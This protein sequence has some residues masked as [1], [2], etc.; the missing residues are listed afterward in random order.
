MACI[1][2]SSKK[3]PLLKSSRV[4]GFRNASRLRGDG[5]STNLEEG[6]EHFICH[7]NCIQTYC[8]NEHIRRAQKKRKSSELSGNSPKRLR[9]SVRGCGA[10]FSF[11]HHCFL[12]GEECNLSIS[13][14]NPNRWRPAFLC[15]TGSQSW[16]KTSKQEILKRCRER[17]DEWGRE[18]KCRISSLLS[19][20]CAEGGRYHK[21]CFSKF[22]CNKPRKPTISRVDSALNQLLTCIT[23]DKMRVWNSIEVYDRYIELGGSNLSRKSLMNVIYEN[24]SPEL[25]IFSSPGIASLLVFRSNNKAFKD[26][27]IMQDVEGDCNYHAISQLAETIK[28]ECPQSD[29]FNYKARLSKEQVTSECSPTLLRL[30][31]SISEK[32]NFT[33][34][35]FMIGHIITSA[36]SGQATSLQIALSVLLSRHRKMID[37]L[38]NYGV[39]SSYDELRR[40]RISAATAMASVP[41]FDSDAGLV[42]VVADNFDTQISSQ[43]CKKSTHGLAMIVTQ[44]NQKEPN[45]TSIT[46]V[47][48]ITRLRAHELKAENLKLGEVAIHHYSGDKKPLLPEHYCLKAVPSLAFLAKLTLSLNTATMDDFAFLK[49]IVSEELCP[50]YGGFNTQKA[51]E[52]HEQP[53]S[54]TAVMYTPF[55]DM[56]P[57]EPDTMKTA[58]VEAQRLTS[59]TGQKWTIFTTDQQLYQVAV[60]ITWAERELFKN[61]I[62][63]L[64]GMHMLMSFVGCIGHLMEGSGLA[65]IMETTFGGVEKLLSGKKYPQ[66]VRALRLVVEELLR[67]FLIRTDMLT[68]K[69]LN[70]TLA[71]LSSCSKTTKLWVDCLIRPVFIIMTFIRAERA[72]DWPLHLYAVEKMLPYFFTA[73]HFNYARYGVYYLRSMQHLPSDLEK[74][75]MNGEHAMHHQAGLWNGIWSDLFIETTYMRYGHSPSGIIGSTLN[76]STLAI[77]AFSHS[78]LTQIMHDLQDLKE[79]RETRAAIIFHK[80]EQTSRL[81]EDAEDRRKIREALSTCIDV[82]D[83]NKHPESGLINIYSGYIVTDPLVNVHNA[84]DIGEAEH[85]HFEKHLTTHFHKKL[86]KKIK[87]MSLTKVSKHCGGGRHTD[88]EFLYARVLG[89]I[90]SPG[91]DVT[92]ETLLSHELAPYPLALFD[93][94]GDMCVTQKSVLKNKLQ[95]VSGK[96]NQKPPSV[97]ILDACALLWRVP[98]PASP[99]KVSDFLNEAVIKILRYAEAASI[100]HIVFDRYNK[101]STKS[102]CRSTR[103]K[104]VNRVYCFTEDMP[105]PKQTLVLNVTANKE[106]IIRMI[107]DRISNMPSVPDKQIIIT[108]PDPQ[109]IQIGG[110]PQETAVFH[111]E[112]DV[113]MAYHMIHEA[114]AGQQ[115]IKVVSEDTDVLIILAHH[116]YAETNGL[117]PNISLCMESCSES[118]SLININ[119]VIRVHRDIMPNILAA[120]ALTGCDTV[121]SFAGV[122]KA[123]AF[124]RLKTFNGLLKL[125]DLSATKEEITES[126]LQFTSMLYNHEKVNDLNMLRAEIFRRKIAGKRHVAPKLCNLPPTMDSFEAHCQRAHYQVALWKAAGLASPP[127]ICPLEC[128][129][130]VKG[131]VLHPQYSLQGQMPP[132]PEEIMNLIKCACKTGCSTALCTCTKHLLS[133]TMFC[134]CSKS[135]RCMNPQTVSVRIDEADTDG[136]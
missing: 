15:K 52:R 126:C 4:V 63:R 74:K 107:V 7:R 109:L 135:S 72:G 128:G 12:C 96:G 127:K 67:P 104:G 114:T 64:G 13:T 77:W 97:I 68:M 8:S 58:L 61:I 38:H 124:K 39:A 25:L 88:T 36:I 20:L 27:R 66:N 120:H 101:M 17:G 82:F 106:Q 76:E 37:E 136:E 29:N 35:A 46:T 134:K 69:E 100:L 16:R 18:V 34:P 103:Q 102:C 116:L 131:S 32:L 132:A 115:S 92:L 125:G 47:P 112:A 80:E 59:L 5:K 98:W 2:C 71:A 65:Q 51:R 28:S 70:G 24:L 75:F 95:V 85:Q 10:T 133:C 93:N 42:Q 73:G 110:G 54:K 105:L 89:I 94:N 90:A 26:L 21:D 41:K 30:L 130:E 53:K 62:P 113:L 55:L 108:G 81:R 79:E 57:A 83:T 121:S 33:L 40:F 129:W 6:A 60:Q 50:E 117:P 14:K 19:D 56:P 78:T 3:P 44:A 118:H 91:R 99:A 43:N 87:N 48:T 11:T 122:G 86:K 31:A 123:T 49:G 9:G 22:Y 23:S 45:K 111:E 84:V 1:I 119:E